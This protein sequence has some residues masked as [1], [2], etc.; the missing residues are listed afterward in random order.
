LSHYVTLENHE[1]W[2]TPDDASPPILDRTL[3]IPLAAGRWIAAVVAI[4]AAL[5]LRFLGLDRF[6]FSAAEAELALTAHQLVRGE[7]VSNDL[8]GAPFTVEWTALFLFGGGTAD[9]IAR[10]AMAAAGVLAILALLSLGRWVGP[11]VAVAA[12][13]LAAMSP[14]LVAASRRIDGGILLVALSLAVV[15]TGLRAGLDRG[16]R[17][18]ILCGVASGALL[19][20][21]PLGIPA[22]ALA[23]LAVF[24]LSRRAHVPTGTEL[25]AGVAALGI[26]L[27]TV[28]TALLSR[29]R[30]L[31]ASIAELLEQL[32]DLHLAEI[33][34]GWYMPAFNAILNEP[35]LIALA[36]VA[37][38]SPSRRGLARSLALWLMASAVV[39]SLLGNTGTAGYALVTLPLALLAGAGAVDIVERLSWESFRRGPALLY[40][41]AVLLMAA[42][43]VSLIG[44]VSGGATDDRA[45]WLLRF[46]L[47]VLVAVLP[48]SLALTAIGARVR[49]D[50]LMLV[51]VA[52]LVVLGAITVRSSVLA[53]SERPVE[54]GDPLAAGASGGELKI[55]V[56]RLQ[57]ISRDLT[58]SQRDSRDPTGGHGLR[59]ALD[60]DIEQPFRWYFR[61]YPNLVVF[62]PDTEPAP[63]A[64]EVVFLDE[65]RDARAVAPGF[66]GATYLYALTTP[67]AYAAPNWSD[68]ASGLF[69]P[70]G[71][72]SFI[73]F[74][75][76]RQLAVEPAGRQ[77]QLLATGA[78]AERLFPSAGP[79]T[80]AD[81]VGA[82]SA[83]GQ[84]NQPRGIAVA[85]DGSVYV[86]DARNSRVQKFSASGEFLLA[87]GSDGSGAGQL[88][89][90]TGA[91][92]AGASGI[93]LDADGNVYVADTWNHRIQVF[94]SDGVYL[95]GW[96]QFFDA[97]DDPALAATQP[98]SFYG[99]RGLAFHDGLLYITDTG[100]ERVQVFGPDGTF[101]RMFGMT[102]SGAGNLLEPVGIAVAVDGTVL[103][104]DS[105]NA[106]I[107]RF[108]SEGAPLDPW[109]V[110]TWI[111]QR[112]FEPYL[113]IGPDGSVFAST[114][115]AGTVLAF[116][117]TGTPGLSLGS[118][119][120]RQPFGIAIGV[121]G[122]NLLVTDG[123]LNAVITVPIPPK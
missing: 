69:R 38:A 26:T 29:P 106:R 12:A 46:A 15:A 114:S 121:G 92:G 62:D 60:A 23:W 74:L 108:T 21:G 119:E 50:R 18:P 24:V 120:L 112:F 70:S 32:W 113:A 71:W 117:P 40:V 116:G 49:G 58:M 89:R 65:A 27:V 8:A 107:A 19:L 83:D 78:V 61:D 16:L 47:V 3:D 51:L 104:A 91:G 7:L 66:N 109:P 10:I 73:D 44:L 4:T 43:V 67:D 84:F 31:P 98:G 54:P 1:A 90:I 9:S 17:W 87:F 53:A 45:E 118:G 11:R 105:H 115:T 14:T 96:G 102:G 93:A 59:I 35:I 22:A 94:T 55:V 56:D 122:T 75:L 48:L 25:L 28:A 42:A 81:R 82:G 99:P 57:R 111:D 110:D 41:G 97:A 88:A 6:P 20:A 30:S 39:M 37:L 77:F 52:G 68:L 79:F 80:L 13:M 100:N 76:N 123:T 101:V 86:V 5:L 64:A 95:R 2:E 72:R 63:A 103:I 36:V 33:G 34:S 85:D